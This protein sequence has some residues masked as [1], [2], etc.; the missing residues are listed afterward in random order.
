MESLPKR[1]LKQKRSLTVKQPA[2]VAERW[3][4][5]LMRSGEVIEIFVKRAADG[6]GN[7]VGYYDCQHLDTLAADA[8]K[9]SGKVA[10]IY[11]RINPMRND[12][13][14][15][16]PNQ[17]AS[18]STAKC[19][20]KS[21]VLR[22]RFLMIDIDSTRKSGLNAT[23]NEKEQ[24]HHL[25]C[26]IFAF[27]KEAGFPLPAQIDTGNGYCLMYG[28]DLPVDDDGLL[29]RILQTLDTRFSNDAA[30]VD[31]SVFDP[32]RLARLPGTMNCKGPHSLD[33]PHRLCKLLR[34]PAGG[35]RAVPRDLFEQLAKT[36]S[37]AP[38]I[39]EAS[40]E[41]KVSNDVI[42]S[43]RAYV[44]K[45]PPAVADSGGDSATY[46]VACRLVIGFG[47]S[48]KQAMP[49]MR[50]YNGRCLPPWTES[51]L[52]RKVEAALERVTQTGLA[53][54]QLAAETTCVE[55]P[56]LSG[57]TFHGWVP[58]F[59]DAST[60]DVL[61]PIGQFALVPQHRWI[62]FYSGWQKLCSN[63]DLPD[64]FLRQ[65]YYGAEL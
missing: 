40:A 58:D 2:S 62:E 55:L 39:Q 19:G 37:R 1:Q 35:C 43:A 47:L 16:S 61:A 65:C 15:R 22:R 20:S 25:L 11:Y 42:Q 28:V 4:S 6:R 34:I 32:A 60:V 5:T 38:D 14:S 41:A 24:A 49:L 64:V 44:A 59:G 45:M 52:V 33:R 7:L 29:Q 31:T 8:E 10:G 63:I 56:P 53:R 12:L 46:T 27:L 9:H 3:L 18:T 17:L 54:G 23:K 30:K 50:E 26:V 57:G 48:Q 51:E 21:D 36:A 13:L